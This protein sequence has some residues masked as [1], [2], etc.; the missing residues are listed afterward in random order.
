MRPH[1]GCMPRD[2]AE[3]VLADVTEDN[4]PDSLKNRLLE[5]K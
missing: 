1:V 2:H 5:E 3:E 4:I